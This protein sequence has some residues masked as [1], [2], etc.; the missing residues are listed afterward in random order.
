M[1]VMCDA[2]C[3]ATTPA[4]WINN[5]NSVLY[6]LCVVLSFLFVVLCSVRQ[7]D[8]VWSNRGRKPSSPLGDVRAL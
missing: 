6:Y 4:G 7:I 3:L 2:R 8:R 1:Y 5:N